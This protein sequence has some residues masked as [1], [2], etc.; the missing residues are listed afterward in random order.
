MH[1][2]P[3]TE[4]FVLFF[5]DL[6]LW[7][8]SL[9]ITLFLRG[10]SPPARE[11]FFLHLVP[12]LL[13]FI[14]WAM[15]FFISDLY[16]SPTLLS[17]QKITRSLF[18]AQITNSII[19]IFFFYFIPYFLITPKTILFIDLIVSFLCV[20]L[21][22]LF[23]APRIKNGK[24]KEAILIGSGADVTLLLNEVN[25]NHRYNFVL[26]QMD[27]FVFEDVLS[28]IKER[29]VRAVIIDTRAKDVGR[30]TP[31]LYDLL[32]ADVTFLDIHDFFEEVFGHI[33]LTLLHDNWFIENITT[34]S[35]NFYDTFKRGMDVAVSIIL[36]LITLIFYPF[37]IGAIYFEDRG[38]PFIKQ[39]RVGKS[40]QPIELYKFR[41][42]DKNEGVSVESESKNRITRVG[43]FLRKTRLDEIPQLWNVLRGDISLIG[44]RPELFD[45]VKYYSEHIPYYMS[46][47]LIVPGLSGWAQIYHDAHPHHTTDITETKNKLSYDLYYIKNRSIFLDL[48]IALKT[49]KTLVSHS[50]R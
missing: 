22:R 12:F 49:L 6:F 31:Q 28:A 1:I 40:F 48:K 3:R 7:V 26:H 34:T 9:W 37:I 11:L 4:P 25:T 20:N 30:I 17:N 39:V 14:L 44:P 35:K 33:P 15:V 16:K 50:G 43:A 18:N 36:G 29:D 41:S 42:M 47:L 46:R 24:R 45:A 21:W 19:A 13:I 38:A 32:F 23:I 10:F 2:R 5:G 8:A 27:T